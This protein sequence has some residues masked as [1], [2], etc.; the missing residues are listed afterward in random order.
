MSVQWSSKYL[1][2]C[3]MLILLLGRNLPREGKFKNCRQ[4]KSALA[5]GFSICC[6]GKALKVCV[7]GRQ[8]TLKSEYRIS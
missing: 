8:A 5:L 3:Q 2:N 4:Q 1:A 6:I 7:K